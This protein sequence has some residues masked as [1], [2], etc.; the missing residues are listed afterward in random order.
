MAHAPQESRPGLGLG[1]RNEVC[2]R[3]TVV[4]FT[5]SITHQTQWPLAAFLT[6]ANKI[7]RAKLATGRAA[8][9]SAQRGV[10]GVQ[11][12]CHEEKESGHVLGQAFL[13]EETDRG[14]D[15]A[16]EQHG[17]RHAQEA[18]RDSSQVYSRGIDIQNGKEKEQ[19]YWKLENE[20]LCEHCKH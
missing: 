4:F 2:I 10:W 18:S 7:S 15:A 19:S 16:A 3:T 8:F 5:F 6:G 12:T 13:P 20:E 9:P 17:H 14:H 1:C 11:R